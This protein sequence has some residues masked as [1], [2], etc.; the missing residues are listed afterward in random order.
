M[1][2][3]P[4]GQL[5]VAAAGSSSSLWGPHKLGA[6]SCA[7]SIKK[8]PRLII[9]RAGLFTNSCQVNDLIILMGVVVVLSPLNLSMRQA[10]KIMLP[11]AGPTPFTDAMMT[12]R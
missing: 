9:L 11:V 10:Y 6:E 5:Q 8:K 3:N 12:P 4:V 7:G 2:I 1:V